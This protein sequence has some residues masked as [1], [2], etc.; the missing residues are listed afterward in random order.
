MRRPFGRLILWRRSRCGAA[1]RAAAIRRRFP[2][3]CGSCGR[4]IRFCAATWR[5]RR[6][7]PTGSWFCR[8]FRRGW[9]LWRRSR[10]RGRC[11]NISFSSWGLSFSWRSRIGMSSRRARRNILSARKRASIVRRLFPP[12]HRGRRGRRSGCSATAR[13][14]T[15][16]IL[17]RSPFGFP[18]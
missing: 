4:T 18:I 6:R 8:C 14:F 7:L 1:A 5:A 2:T 17:P 9:P 11:A 10:R 3:R 15:G 16:R 12:S 13:R